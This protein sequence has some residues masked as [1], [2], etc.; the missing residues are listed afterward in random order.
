MVQLFSPETA[1][2]DSLA[3]EIDPMDSV[4]SYDLLLPELDNGKRGNWEVVMGNG[5]P[6]AANQYF[7]SSR[8]QARRDLWMQVGM[9]RG[10]IFLCLILL[11]LRAKN[12]L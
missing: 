1:A 9:A 5:T 11:R 7:L 2:V 4:F 10:V 12:M 3:Y 8:I 6:G